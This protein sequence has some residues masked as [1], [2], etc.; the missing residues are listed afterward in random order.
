MLRRMKRDIWLF[1]ISLVWL[2]ILAVG[3]PYA[4]YAMG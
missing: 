2:A 4:L 1:R 3:V